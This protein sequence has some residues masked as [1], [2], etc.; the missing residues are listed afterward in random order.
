MTQLPVSALAGGGSCRG[1][2][3]IA[4]LSCDIVILTLAGPERNWELR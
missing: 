2:G 3:N 4:T 1:P